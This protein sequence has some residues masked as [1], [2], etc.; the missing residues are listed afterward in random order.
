MHVSLL[1]EDSKGKSKNRSVF[2]Y[3]CHDGDI[4]TVAWLPNRQR[5][6]SAGEDGYVHVWQA[7]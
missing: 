7:V 2:T 4:W 6:A 5:I 1:Y 3:S